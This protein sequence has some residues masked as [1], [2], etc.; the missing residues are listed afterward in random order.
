MARQNGAVT[1]P[2]ALDD[3]R[4]FLP[5][6]DPLPAFETDRHGPAVASYLE[7]LDELGAEL[8]DRLEDGDLRPA[9]RDLD[10]PPGGLFDELS[11]REVVRVCLL[12]GFFASGYVNQIG[13]DPV[14]RLPAGAAVPLYRSSDL[15]GRKPILSYDVLCLHNWR[16][17]DPEADFALGNLDTVQQ[18]RN[19]DDE[20]WFVVIHVAIE[21]AAAPGLA[22]C[23]RAHDAIRADDPGALRAELETVADS[24]EE[25]TAI[26]RRMTE[27][28]EP[29][30]FATEFRPYYDGF[31]EVVYEGVDAFE[32]NP[33]TYRGGSGAQSCV[34]P[35]IDATLGVDHEA[36]DL[37]DKLGDMRSYM[38]D[39]HRAAIQR[40]D[41]GPDV[42]PYVAER[43]DEALTAAFN[44]CVEGL[45]AFRETHLKQVVQY[46]RQVTG[47]TTGTG[48]T[49]YMPFLGKM[50]EETEAQT[51]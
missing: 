48:G 19:L 33:R 50:R 20:R 46:I 37:I 28:N 31:D 1:A 11:G 21:E 32:G 12:S 24:L 40:F 27:G 17:R 51:L 34:L 8:P 3:E 6:E 9:V 47:E 5:R 14:D 42:R 38:P 23:S 26:M 45:G 43:D 29:E 2:L 44:R 35:S 41:E 15:L 49:D 30:V 25:Q 16:R 18:F 10:T 13:S 4:G 7:R 36:T 39:Q 22:A